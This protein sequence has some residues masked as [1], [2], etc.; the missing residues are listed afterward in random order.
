MKVTA[1]TKQNTPHVPE[2][3]H[4][5]PFCFRFHGIHTGATFVFIYNNLYLPANSFVKVQG[6][7]DEGDFEGRL[8]WETE[9]TLIQSIRSDETGWS[10]KVENFKKI[11][12][13]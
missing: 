3:L 4:Q 11:I 5:L 8:E 7:G 10:K 6:K 12:P 13:K 9:M 1:K 2:L